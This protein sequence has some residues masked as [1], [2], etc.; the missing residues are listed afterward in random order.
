MVSKIVRKLVGFSTIGQDVLGY[1]VVE[2]WEDI[3]FAEV[4]VWVCKPH[5]PIPD[6]ILQ[7][8]DVNDIGYTDC[9]AREHE[10]SNEHSVQE[11]V[12]IDPSTE[13]LD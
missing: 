1:E 6:D 3:T 7:Q 10:V 12:A 13:I 2:Y 4:L 11:H 9:L 5:N 8:R